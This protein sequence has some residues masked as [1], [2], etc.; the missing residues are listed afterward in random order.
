M[1]GTRA[2]SG[3]AARRFRKRPHRLD[4]VEQPLVHVDVDDLGAA[5]D[6]LAGDGQGLVAAAPPGRAS[7]SAG[8]PVTLVRS[9]TLTKLESGR[10]TRGSMPGEAAE[11]RAPPAATRGAT[12]RTASAMARM[13]A[14]RRP[15]A[16]AHQVDETR[17]APTR[18]GPGPS[19]PAS[20]RSPRRRWEGRRSGRSSP[21]WG[22]PGRAPR[23]AACISPGPRAQLMPT[24][25]SGTW[26][27]EIQKAST[28]L[29]REVAPGQVGD[30]HRGHDRDPPAR[31]LEGP[32]DGGERGLAVQGVEDRLDDQEV[33]VRPRGGPWP[34]RGRRPPARRR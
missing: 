17:L 32:L 12:P 18:P 3:S 10:I 21:G 34:A 9:P 2:M 29:S 24:A 26:D 14:G 5:L 7:R 22:R 30:R 8:D 20:R 1:T 11:A 25:R 16:A 15:A 28:R 23:G 33:D 27:T 19:A 31:L 6:L 4:R 13:C